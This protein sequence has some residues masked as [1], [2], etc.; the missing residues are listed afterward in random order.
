MNPN[1]HQVQLKDWITVGTRKAVVS[2]IYEDSTDKIEIVYLDDRN[3]AINEDAFFEDG[4]WH[5]VEAG[6]NGGYADNIP[7]LAEYVRKLKAGRWWEG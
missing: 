5:F 7:R 1:L 4:K 3:R 2:K 6:P